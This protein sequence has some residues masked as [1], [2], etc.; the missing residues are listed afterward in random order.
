[1]RSSRWGRLGGGCYAWPP[2]SRTN[3]SA[4]RLLRT[5][6]LLDATDRF[7]SEV[8]IPLV[9]RRD[10]L[11]NFEFARGS[12]LSTETRQKATVDS[13][14]SIRSVFVSA[15]RIICCGGRTPHR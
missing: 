2:A 4:Q 3:R 14:S 7:I 6:E 11:G 12:P 5:C 9:V 8:N 13:N 15:T 10:V 1:M